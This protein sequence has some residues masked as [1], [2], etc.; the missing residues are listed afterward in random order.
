M[1]IRI[2]ILFAT[3]GEVPEIFAYGGSGIIEARSM[4]GA[5]IGVL[6]SGIGRA[7]ASEATDRICAEFRP[8]YIISSGICGGTQAGTNIGDLLVADCVCY[9]SREMRLASP[10]LERMISFLEQIGN[11]RVGK[12]Q[13]FDHFVGPETIVLPDVIGVDVESYGVATAARQHRMP[14]VIV[15]AVSDLVST[16][17]FWDEH[18]MIARQRLYLFF[19]EYL[20]LAAL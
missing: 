8:N 6:V 1:P 19:R 11:Y 17:E 18:F 3:I 16:G 12:F 2:G 14:L 9:D 15:R 7:N 5:D 13:T 20:A 10:E 4:G